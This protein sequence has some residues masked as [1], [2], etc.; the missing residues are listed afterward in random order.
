MLGKLLCDNN[1]EIIELWYKEWKDSPHPHPEISEALLKDGLP[2]Q[3]RVIGEQLQKDE[4]AELPKNM[5]KITDR[6]DP[7]E[8][9][10][11]DIPI[12]EVVHEYRIFIKV[13]RRFIHDKEPTVPFDEYSYFYE[14]V[15]ELTAEAV[16]RYAKYQAEVVSNDRSEYLAGLSHQMRT[17][18]TVIQ[19]HLEAYELQENK[20]L[21]KESYESLK[22]NADRL[23][24]LI[25][26]IMRLERFKSEDIPVRP[27]SIYPVDFL[28][29]IVADHQFLARQ[30]GIDLE[31]SVSRSLAIYTDPDLLMDALGNLIDNAVK[32]TDKGYVR[33][34]AQDDNERIV[35]KVEDSGPGIPKERQNN[36]FSITTSSSAKGAGIGLS[37]VKRVTRALGGDAYMH[38]EPGKGSTFYI[39]IP[40]IAPQKVSTK[41]NN[42]MSNQP[43]AG[44][45]LLM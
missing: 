26:G 44:S 35:F 3:L 5:W 8:R 29:Q 30:K 9:V 7:E 19:N 10:F 1:D 32:Y 21:E 22:R 2:E 23:E 17:P 37:I 31:V 34:E 41:E 36:I 13:V 15:Y 33:V 18:L 6:L 40:K 14:S 11:Q 12:E 42:D 45:N 25:N 39:D 28:D 27:Q 43:Q 38:T 4:L 24:F 20:E 16:K